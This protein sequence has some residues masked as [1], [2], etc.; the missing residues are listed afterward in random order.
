MTHYCDD[1]SEEERARYNKLALETITPRLWPDERR[2]IGVDFAGQCP[3][4]GHEVSY[5]RKF[6]NVRGMARMTQWARRA[7]A[8][9]VRAGGTHLLRGDQQFKVDCVCQRPHAERPSDRSGCGLPI[10]LHVRWP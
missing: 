4:C 10:D 7:L 1:Y 5:R 6:V 8:E 2:P 3:R 9:R